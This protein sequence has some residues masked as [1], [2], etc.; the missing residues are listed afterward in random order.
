MLSP[1]RV[2]DA[3]PAAPASHAHRPAPPPAPAGPKACQSDDDCP[4]ENFCAERG[5]CEAIQTRTNILY[6][7]YREGSFQEILG[8]YW[9]KKG[10][11]GYKV[12]AP[13]YWHYWSPKS[14]FRAVAPFYWHYEDYATNYRATVIVPG[15]PI[16]WS[17]QPDASSF[18]V[19]PI[20]YRSTKF[21]WA[22]PIFGSFEIDDPD[23][24]SSFGALAFLYWWK[25]SPSRDRDV[26]FPLLFSTRSPEQRVHLRRSR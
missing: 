4:G 8:L 2:A 25:R 17:S 3:Q 21:G 12:V 7:Y 22:A 15:L 14:R 20:F 10:P 1:F 16:S 5:V 24:K 6:L 19:W 18:G 11:S 9:S 23:H 13:I 26:L